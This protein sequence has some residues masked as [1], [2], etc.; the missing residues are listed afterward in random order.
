[1]INLLE[2]RP[3][4]PSKFRT[5]NCVERNDDAPGRYNTNSQIKFKT[6]ILRSCFCDYDDAYIHGKGTMTVPNTATAGSPDNTNN[7]D[8]ALFK[9]CVPF[10]DYYRDEPAAT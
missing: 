1:M 3:N 4:Q 5:K 10:A 9:K 6:S 2:N 7:R 8:K